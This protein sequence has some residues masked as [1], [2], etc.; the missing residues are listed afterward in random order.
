MKH[1]ILSLLIVFCLI[2]S[3]KSDKKDTETVVEDTTEIST[4]TTNPSETKKVTEI[5]EKPAHYNDIK[6]VAMSLSSKSGSNVTGNIVFKQEL[7]A[8]TMIAVVDG[9]S[10][11]EHALHIN[12]KAD[13]SANDGSSSGNIWKGLNEGVGT[14][15]ANDAGHGTMTKITEDWCI[16]CD[17]QS[18]NILGKAIV[19]YK[20]DTIL[21]CGEI[22][23]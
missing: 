11:G 16:G 4:E 12:E 22:K 2:A 9:L 10:P 13:C 8:I 20:G 5:K 18:K 17:D 23:Q 21:A 3:C 6:K 15:T 19:I 7:G 14:F 1:H